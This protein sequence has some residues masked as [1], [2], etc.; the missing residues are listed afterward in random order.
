MLIR[1]GKTIIFVLLASAL[2]LVQ[3]SLISAWPGIFSQLN[4]ILI[5]LI[6][7]LFFFG[8]EPAL[9]LALLFGFWL[10][11]FSFEFFGR[12]LITLVLVV[13][14]TQWI[15][16]SWLTN[17]S[18]YSFLLLILIA[19]IG[20]NFLTSGLLFLTLAD[21]GFLFLSQKFFWLALVEQ[22][23]WSLLAAL[24]LFNLVASMT[25]K[26]QPVF[27]EKKPVL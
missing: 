18:L 21:R 22:S 27:L 14:G 4:L 17:R 25:R 9:F 8:F 10:D 5:L 1:I 16:K 2:A 24:L 3:F 15:L 23:A 20:Y 12:Q 7:T 13:L 19:T 11:I 26:L 6:F